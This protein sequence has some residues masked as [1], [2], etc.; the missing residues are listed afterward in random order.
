MDGITDSRDMSLS[1]L[2]EIVKKREAWCTAVMG[3][4][5]VRHDCAPE[6]QPPFTRVNHWKF[7]LFNS[8][9]KGE[10]FTSVNF[11]R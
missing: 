1:E 9:H 3:L 5:R 8:S 7:I 2:R 10:W 4:Q 6:K 11:E